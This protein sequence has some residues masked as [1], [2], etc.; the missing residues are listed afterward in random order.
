M[1]RFH[2]P[3]PPSQ[4]LQQPHLTHLIAAAVLLI[5]LLAAIFASRFGTAMG[6]RTR[7]RRP[8][9]RYQEAE[10]L[11][12]HPAA[13]HFPSDGRYQHIQAVPDRQG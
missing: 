1:I 3:L 13:A 5:L 4:W 10:W 6:R 2:H 7:R 8:I 12:E 11:A 9:T